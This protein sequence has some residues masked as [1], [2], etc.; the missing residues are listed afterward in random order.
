MCYYVQKLIRMIEVHRIISTI[1]FTGLGKTYGRCERNTLPKAV[2][3]KTVLVV[4]NNISLTV[5][6]AESYLNYSSVKGFLG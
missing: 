1:C 3:A 4:G 5:A 6:Y 2:E